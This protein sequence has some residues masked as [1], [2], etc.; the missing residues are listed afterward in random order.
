MRLIRWR[1][2]L[3]A[4]MEAALQ[5]YLGE[6][7]WVPRHALRAALENSSLDL[8]ARQVQALMSIADPD[9]EG[10]VDAGLVIDQGFRTLRVLKEQELLGHMA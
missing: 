1:S 8:S 5:P 3:Q 6:T 2:A 4:G 7:E 10:Y 9:D